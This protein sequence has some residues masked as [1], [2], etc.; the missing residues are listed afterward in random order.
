MTE[1]DNIKKEEKK[2]TIN[3]EE[4]DEE[5]REFPENEI[6]GPNSDIN[7]KNQKVPKKEKLDLI[8]I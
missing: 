1:K 2:D 8:S 6:I 4:L 5:P 3:N 7:L